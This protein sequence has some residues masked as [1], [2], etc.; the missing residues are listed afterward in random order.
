MQQ[1]TLESCAAFTGVSSV[2]SKGRTFKNRTF[3]LSRQLEHKLMHVRCFSTALTECPLIRLKI[4]RHAKKVRKYSKNPHMLIP[5]SYKHNRCQR[6]CGKRWLTVCTWDNKH[7]YLEWWIDN[8]ADEFNQSIFPPVCSAGFEAATS[9]QQKF[10]LFFGCE[11]L[12]WA[13]MGDKQ[14]HDW[15]ARASEVAIPRMVSMVLTAAQ[16]HPDLEKR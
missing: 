4:I 6:G 8:N 12:K 5:G 1:R 15:P 7:I 13:F 11:W 16:A 2:W 9:K 3:V 10:P 14:R